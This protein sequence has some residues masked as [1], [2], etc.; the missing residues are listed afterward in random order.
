MPGDELESQGR[1]AASWRLRERQARTTRK[2]SETSEK[3]SV[4]V[5]STLF[6]PLSS[7]SEDAGRAASSRT[8]LSFVTGY[9]SHQL[10]RSQ[11][12]GKGRLQGSPCLRTAW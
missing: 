11:M 4:R 8:L 10:E 1:D 9:A 5:E 12:N 3:T 6:G 2:N 7:P